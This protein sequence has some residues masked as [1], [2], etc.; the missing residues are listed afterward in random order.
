MT[1]DKIKSITII[2]KQEY[3]KQ[4]LLFIR[5]LPPERFAGIAVLV[6]AVAHGCLFSIALL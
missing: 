6:A 5:K 4:L 2:I 1:I 3:G